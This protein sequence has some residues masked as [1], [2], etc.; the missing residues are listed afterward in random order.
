MNVRWTPTSKVTYLGVLSYLNE[1]WT[2]KELQNFVDTV[3][4]VISQIVSEPYIPT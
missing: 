3:E 2:K 1:N 4:K